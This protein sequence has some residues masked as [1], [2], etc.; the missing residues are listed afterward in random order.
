[1]LVKLKRIYNKTIAVTE[2]ELKL[3]LRFPLSFFAYI[4]V[5]PFYSLIPFL[6]L[7]TGLFALQGPDLTSIL[8]F[9]SELK[10][11]DPLVQY[12]LYNFLKSAFSSSLNQTNYLSWLIVGNLIFV[13]SKNGFD[14]FIEKFIFEK[15]WNTIQGTLLAPI[16]RYLMLIGYILITLIESMIFFIMMIIISAFLFPISIFQ[17]ISIFLIAC[18]MIVASGG[19]GLIKG[20]INLSTESYRVFFELG[21]FLILFLSCYTIPFEYFP[22]FLQ[23]IIIINPFYHGVNLARNIF[24]GVYTPDIFLSLLFIII[25]AIIT[26]IIGVYLFNKIWKKFGIHGY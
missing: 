6:I 16:N 9:F 19:I 1:M 26:A 4:F 23:G 15:Y 17:I 21:Q 8:I 22:E 2:K 3:K 12:Q 18:L 25:F 5:K 11:N 13:F 10:F 20:S 24:Y 14:A 7:Y